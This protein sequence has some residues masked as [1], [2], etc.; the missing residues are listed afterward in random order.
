MLS[1]LESYLNN[2]NQYT[3]VNGTKSSTMD[4]KCGVPQGSVLGPLLFLLYANDIQNCTK[5]VLKQ[6]RTTPMV[7]YLLMT[8]K[9]SSQK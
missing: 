8:T 4:I 5:E 1:L 2:R 7:L 9:H 6:E 3:I